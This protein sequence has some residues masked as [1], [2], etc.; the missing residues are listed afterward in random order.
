MRLSPTLCFAITHRAN[1]RLPQV[2][3]SLYHPPKNLTEGFVFKGAHIK[4][5]DGIQHVHLRYTDGLTTLSLFESEADDVNLWDKPP[6]EVE[7]RQVEEIFIGK[8][9]CKIV[10]P[11]GRV[12]I[13][14]WTT[15]PVL[16]HDVGLSFTLI[17]EI[18]KSEMI[19]IAK[20]LI[21]EEVTKRR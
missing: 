1:L 15:N 21:L 5:M 10:S 16:E 7:H 8:V 2:T 11:P 3:S 9:N 20:A 18:S 4:K 17:G 12:R 13:L 14:H 19:A 6:P